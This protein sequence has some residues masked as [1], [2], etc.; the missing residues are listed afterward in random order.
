MKSNEALDLERYL[1]QTTLPELGIEGQAALLASKVLVVGLGGLGA[2]VATYLAA[3]GVGELG[4]CDGDKVE[5][6]NLHRQVLFNEADLGTSKVDA[7]ATNI[8]AKNSKIKLK[9]ES[10]FLSSENVFELLAGFDLV[11]DCTDS[12]EARYLINDTCLA[13]GIP[14]V[15]G[16]LHKFQG[17]CSVFAPGGPCFRCYMPA[18][19]SVPTC[20]MTG[21]LGVLPGLVGCAQATAVLQLLL[22]RS[23]PLVG[24]MQFFDL[25]TFDFYKIAIPRQADC[26]CRAFDNDAKSVPLKSSHLE[27][28]PV[29]SISV[30][31]LHEQL[32]KPDLTLLDV[33]ELAEFRTMRFKNAVHLPLSQLSISKSSI[34]TALALSN[35]ESKSESKSESK[36]GSVVVYCRSGQRSI[37]AVRILQASGV[38]NVV[39]LDGGIM[40]WHR[41]FQGE[42]LDSDF[43]AID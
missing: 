38:E 36:L 4:L 30:Q 2:P 34:E 32:Q 1:R 7:A 35:Q 5:L 28:M 23:S 8:L 39:N 21:V 20:Q 11:V 19:A 43:D 10:R 15:Y 25:L 37:Q 14:F 22:G 13:L 6:S 31:K 17:Q 42:G 29:R 3:A 40:E 9:K 18:F 26:I 41:S 27:S 24:V 12:L 33:R 16:A